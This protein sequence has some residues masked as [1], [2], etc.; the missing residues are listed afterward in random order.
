MAACMNRTKPKMLLF[1]HICSSGYVTG[2]EKLLMF[3]IR[4]LIPSFACTLVVPREGNISAQARALGIPVIVQEIPLVISLYLVE[5]EVSHDIEQKMRDPAW[6]A[7]IALLD[8]ERPDIILTNTCVHPLPAIA[9][10]ALGIPVV[11][12]VMEAIKSAPYT[13]AVVAIIENYADFVVAISETTAAPLRTPGLI[14]KTMVIHPSWRPEELS[15]G[16]WEMNRS[17]RRSLLG[18]SDDQKLIGYVSGSIYE[19]K[20]LHHF[21]QMAIEVA[22]RFPNARY[23]IVGTPTDEAYFERCFD[24]VRARGLMDRFRWI[25]F[26]ERI[27]TVYPAIDVLV[28]PSLVPEGFGMTAL[29]G[30]VFGKPVVVYGA[31]GLAEIA[32][33]TGNEAY[34]VPIGDIGGL[35]VRV[36]GLLGD[37]ARLAAAG[38]RN[39]EKSAVAFGIAAYREKLRR[40]VATLTVRGYIP[41]RLVRGSGPTVYLFEN[42]V[43]MPFASEKAFYNAG[44]RFEEVREVSDDLIATLPHGAS[45]GEAVKRPRAIRRRRKGSAAKGRRTVRKR[46]RIRAAGARGRRRGVKTRTVFRRR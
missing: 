24:R 16:S 12:A 46:R 11:W 38:T 4:E 5:T 37:E 44:Y 40:L 29:E 6:I 45:I 7:L 21:M 41:L 33:V 26:E 35:F 2:A 3:M 20:G 25:R 39:A 18:I 43:L 36:S 13:S 14:G 17:Y 30:M 8:R 28:V 9:A 27:E 15:S 32:A 23:L 19:T 34:C 31:G 1:S 10:K 22:E 42:G